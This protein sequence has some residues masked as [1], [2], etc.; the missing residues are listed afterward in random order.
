MPVVFDFSSFTF[1]I[2]LQ[3]LHGSKS[4]FASQKQKNRYAVFFQAVFRHFL[5]ACLS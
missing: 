2:L 4:K 1:T 5:P 3:T